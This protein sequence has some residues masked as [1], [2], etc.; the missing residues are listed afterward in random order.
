MLCE[1]VRACL[2]ARIAIVCGAL[3]LVATQAQADQSR[4]SKRA[5]T[6]LDKKSVGTDVLTLVHFGAR[7]DGQT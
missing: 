5:R 6:F 4:A 1:Q 3:L 2:V 7:Y